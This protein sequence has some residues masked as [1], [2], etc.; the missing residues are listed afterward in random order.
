MSTKSL[1]VG[2]RRR[3]PESVRTEALA[4]GRRLLI[5]GGPAAITLKAIGAEMAMSHANLI[6]HF[7]SAEAFQSQLKTTIV[8]ELT[9]TVTALIRQGTE[10]PD[11]AEIVDTVFT[12]YGPGGIGRLVAWSASAKPAD[13]THGLEQALGEL[14]AVVEPL[15]E[16]SGAAA[17]TRAMVILVSIMALGDSLIGKPLAKWVGND[18]QEMRH[19]TVWILEQLRSDGNPPLLQRDRVEK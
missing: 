5:D 6:H 3:K 19:L 9:R 18:P 14:V 12:A 13:E 8:E 11:L 7:G 15:I 1:P 17:R 16:G 2:D 4:I 10:G